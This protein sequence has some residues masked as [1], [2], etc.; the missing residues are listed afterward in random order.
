MAY[1]EGR[2][3]GGGGHLP[4]VRGSC[5]WMRPCGAAGL[6]LEADVLG[7]D[8][9]IW[10]LDPALTPLPLQGSCTLVV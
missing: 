8:L 2:R 5:P 4:L 9:G 1:G 10:G 6:T 3:K 7:G